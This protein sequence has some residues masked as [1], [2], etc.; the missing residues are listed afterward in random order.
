MP[1]VSGRNK[2][3]LG[4]DPPES[5]G[6]WRNFSD[7][8]RVPSNRSLQ[9]LSIEVAGIAHVSCWVPFPGVTPHVPIPSKDE[10]RM[11]AS[12]PVLAG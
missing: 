9:P 2:M 11:K 7:R 12:A 3:E 6:T 1:V 10:P 5:E 4:G 8:G